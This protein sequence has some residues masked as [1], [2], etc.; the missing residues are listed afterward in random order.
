MKKL[1]I[2]FLLTFF[3]CEDTQAQTWKNYWYP[4]AHDTTFTPI[5]VEAKD[6]VLWIK[7]KVQKQQRNAVNIKTDLGTRY[8]KTDLN[9]K[10][11]SEHRNKEDYWRAFEVVNNT[12][13]QKLGTDTLYHYGEDTIMKVHVPSITW[14]IGDR[15]KGQ[16]WI[17]IQD[18]II[19]FDGNNFHS[20]STIALAENETDSS[21]FTWGIPDLDLI[22]SD[23]DGGLFGTIGCCMGVYDRTVWYINPERTKLIT[24]RFNDIYSS[25]KI[26]HNNNLLI[27]IHDTLA[28]LNK[29]DLS[30][31][32]YVV[33]PFVDLRLID[34]DENNKLWFTGYKDGAEILISY[35]WNTWEIKDSEYIPFF[36]KERNIDIHG[37][38]WSIIDEKLVQLTGSEI[39]QVGFGVDK[40]SQYYEE[41][42]TPC[43][44][45]VGGGSPTV[46]NRANGEV[47]LGFDGRLFTLDNCDLNIYTDGLSSL[48]ENNAGHLMENRRDTLGMYEHNGSEWQM[49]VPPRPKTNGYMDTQM[50][51]QDPSGVYWGMYIEEMVPVYGRGGAAIS[52]Y[53]SYAL[54]SETD[55][56]YTAG[57]STKYPH[58]GKLVYDIIKDNR[59][60]VWVSRQEALMKYDGVTWT[61][62][63]YTNHIRFEKIAS[64]K[65]G[66]IWGTII[67][68]IGKSAAARIVGKFNGQSWELFSFEKE[69][70]VMNDFIDPDGGV[71]FINNDGLVYT[72]DGQEWVYYTEADGLL[73]RNINSMAV[74]A[75]RNIWIGTDIGISKLIRHPE[76]IIAMAEQPDAKTEITIYPNPVDDLLS[77]AGVSATAELAIYAIDGRKMAVRQNN[78][79]LDVSALE[80]GVYLLQIQTGTSIQ[81]KQFIKY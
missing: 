48:F 28:I 25:P 10:V 18:S 1:I 36:V 12:E 7:L 24:Q 53:P 37:D 43:Y 57:Q 74:D 54:I 60:I 69:F 27:V 71:W 59:N 23:K 33:S 11:I 51:V 20:F 26:D 68:G 41:I 4:T 9:G 79:Q 16:V 46:I 17:P 8:V 2:L 70:E 58:L 21:L 64:D 19:G 76:T 56:R 15:H 6:S 22:V 38:R 31:D 35:D 80:K 29:Q 62:Y 40:R 14:H 78:N 30:V 32:R 77:I 34:I 67:N 39:N 73:S 47:W 5:S 52:Y 75:D 66:N 63:P 50:K 45:T 3:I 72:L 61:H 49:V 81:S 13:P 44:H 42:E 65:A 55:P